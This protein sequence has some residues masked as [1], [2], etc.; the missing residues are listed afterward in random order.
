MGVGAA[1][2]TPTHARLRLRLGSQKK[3]NDDSRISRPSVYTLAALYMHRFSLIYLYCT[4]HDLLIMYCSIMCLSIASTSGVAVL[5]TTR[6]SFNLSRRRRRTLPRFPLPP[7]PIA[8]AAAERG[9]GVSGSTDNDDAAPRVSLE[10]PVLSHRVRPHRSQGLDLR[11]GVSSFAASARRSSVE[12]RASRSS[13]ETERPSTRSNRDGAG[14]SGAGGERVLKKRR[15]TR[16]LGNYLGERRRH[17]PG[18]G[19]GGTA[20][21]RLCSPRRWGS[22]RA[23]HTRRRTWGYRISRPHPRPGPSRPLHRA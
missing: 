23:P 19:A 12:R 11:P 7:R 10:P 20:D 3:Q 14:R 8:A 1:S 13:V 22:A 9:R 5:S 21:S 15:S 18:G 17:A 6:L 4:V 16:E 2:Q